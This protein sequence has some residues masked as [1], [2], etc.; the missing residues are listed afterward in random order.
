M[1]NGFS[2]VMLS[3]NI[4]IQ[5][6]AES[7]RRRRFSLNH[8]RIQGNVSPD[9]KATI[10]RVMTGFDIGKSPSGLKTHEGPGQEECRPGGEIERARNR[11]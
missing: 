11:C 7:G 2:F 9:R 6:A 4:K 8:E 10:E 1:V 5:D 3:A